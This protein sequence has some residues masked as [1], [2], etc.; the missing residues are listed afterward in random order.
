[1]SKVLVISE[2]SEREYISFASLLSS[3]NIEIIKQFEEASSEKYEFVV[4][5]DE[6]ALNNASRLLASNGRLFLKQTDTS[7][8]SLIMAGFVDI[9]TETSGFISCALFSQEKDMVKLELVDE[10][11][12]LTSDDIEKAAKSSACSPDQ[13][14]KQLPEKKKRACKN[15]TCG[16]AEKEAGLG[17]KIDLSAPTKSSCGNCGLGDAFRCAGCPYRGLPA[18][19]PGEKIAL[20]SD[21]LADDI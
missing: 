8:V 9:R 12:L 5:Q 17:T 20:P 4:L 3:D 19:T 2:N 1:M 15:C 18:F 16:L 11:S 14:S 7:K 10:D 21:F 6:Q 13:G